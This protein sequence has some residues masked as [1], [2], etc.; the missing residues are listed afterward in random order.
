MF[1]VFFFDLETVNVPYQEFCEAYAAG[2]Y[3]LD[4]LKDCYNGELIE[5]EI[6]IERQHVHIFYRVNNNPVLNMIKFITTNYKGK[7]N[8]SKNKNSDFEISSYR[9][10]LFG[11]SAS[12]FF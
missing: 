7:P 4:R 9:Y 12:G 10:Q 2:C 3:H 8:F 6:E 11:H 1:A 5:K